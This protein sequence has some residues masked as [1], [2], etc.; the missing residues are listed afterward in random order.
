MRVKDLMRTRKVVSVR[1][2]DDVA[3]AAQLLAWAG[4]RHLPVLDHGRVVGVFTERDLLRYRAETG[5]HGALDPVRR[6]MTSPAVVV[7]ADD[8]IEKAMGLMV[9][10]K[11]GCLPV[12]DGH[13]LVGIL[14]STDVV[15]RVFVKARES[16]RHAHGPLVK[17][18]MKSALATVHPDE[19]ILEAVARMV[20][21][22]IRHLPVVDRSGRLVGI[23]SDRDVRTAI[24]DPVEAL[25]RESAGLE[26]MPVSSVMTTD[27]V[28]ARPEG[29][30]ADI[31]RRF[32]DDRVGAMPVVAEG[33][34]LVGIISYLDVLEASRRF[35]P[36]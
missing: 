8:E 12:V 34:S 21:R 4:V 7:N 11:R 19:P 20:E 35:V 36:V 18:A 5:G 27:V 23:L 26:S 32:V 1:A 22:Q 29:S 14:T 2:D 31:A 10:G 13:E 3:M 30:L 17:D 28:T 25:A 24:G 33:G 6:F 16:A 15:G 9:A